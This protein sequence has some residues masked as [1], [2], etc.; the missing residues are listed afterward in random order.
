MTTKIVLPQVIFDK[1]ADME[2]QVFE[3]LTV[4]SV[5]RIAGTFMWGD[6]HFQ[7]VKVIETYGVKTADK[8]YLDDMG[9]APIQPE[10]ARDTRAQWKREKNN[11]R[12]R[13]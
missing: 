7:V 12:G 6:A 13:R 5:D 9:P 1:I 3:G 8:F 2:G 10:A 11:Y 4:H